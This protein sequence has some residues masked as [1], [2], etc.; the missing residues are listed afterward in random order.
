VDRREV[1]KLLALGSALPALPPDAFALFVG[2]H[3][4]LAS[5]PRLKILNAHQDAT[6]TAMAELILPQTDTPGAKT[7][8]VNEFIDLIVADW[9]SEDE[10]SFFLS[11]LANLD[12]RSQSLFS[13]N[14]V[15][16]SATQQSDILRA[17]GDEMA[18]ESTALRTAPRG[19]RGTDPEPDGN[20]YFIF[21]SL[22]LT[23]YFTSEIGFR[24]QLH[25]ETIPGHF[26]GCVPLA[27]LAPGKYS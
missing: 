3:Q 2:L 14:F 8:R 1:I 22:A 7:A 5:T 23:G 24:Q 27:T 6:V 11:G 12:A 9:Y 10:R 18:E 13:K 16:T 25:E 15:D 4:S 21:R 26:D 20:F 19:D 17:L